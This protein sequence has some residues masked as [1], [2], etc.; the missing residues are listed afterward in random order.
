MSDEAYNNNTTNIDTES[1]SCT[2]GHNGDVISTA[3]GVGPAEEI[4]TFGRPQNDHKAPVKNSI[5]PKVCSS[6]LT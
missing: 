4:D 3:S 1:T 2:E 6:L 5:P